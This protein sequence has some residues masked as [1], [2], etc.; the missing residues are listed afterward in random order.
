M[1]GS[2]VVATVLRGSDQQTRSSFA[3][4]SRAVIPVADSHRQ[5]TQVDGGRDSLI[6]PPR[7]VARCVPLTRMVCPVKRKIWAALVGRSSVCLAH[8]Q[9]ARSSYPARR[10][11]GDHDEPRIEGPNERHSARSRFAP[12]LCLS[13]FPIVRREQKISLS[14]PCCFNTAGSTGSFRSRLPVAAK[15]ALVTA[16]TM[17]DVPASPIPPGASEFC[18]MCT[19]TSG[20]SSIRRI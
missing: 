11:A 1:G 8:K 14:Q 10:A 7:A 6:R 20:A 13:A 4:N 17:H 15:I 5:P 2:R 18:T 16:G 19:S 3:R 9:C 12:P